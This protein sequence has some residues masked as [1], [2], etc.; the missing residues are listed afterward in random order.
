MVVLVSNIST[1]HWRFFNFLLLPDTVG[2]PFSVHVFS[3]TRDSSQKADGADFYTDYVFGAEQTARL[4]YIV[5][6]KLTRL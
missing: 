6:V 5:D 3:F 1:R 4:N 2:S